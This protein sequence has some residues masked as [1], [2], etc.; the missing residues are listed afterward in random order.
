MT[1]IKDLNPNVSD[2][3]ANVGIRWEGDA[4]TYV[5][6]SEDKI[7]LMTAVCTAISNGADFVSGDDN[8]AVMRPGTSTSYLDL[9]IAD[10][11]D[12]RAEAAAER[13]GYGG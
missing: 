3:I 7:A 8:S 13:R 11:P 10:A 12:Y 6:E 2:T 5:L 9:D 1:T 4:E